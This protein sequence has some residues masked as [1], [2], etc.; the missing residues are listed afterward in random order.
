[1]FQLETPFR[2]DG[3]TVVAL[4]YRLFG[5]TAGKWLAALV[6]LGVGAVHVLA[7]HRAR[8]GGIPARRHLD[9]VCDLRVR[10]PGVLQLLLSGVS[11]LPFR[12]G[13]ARSTK[14]GRAYWRTPLTP[15]RL[16]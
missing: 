7:L 9:D 5:F 6:G 1:M 12:V 15:K 11:A 10:Q 13:R 8:T 16:P 14:G 2:P 4:L 3:L